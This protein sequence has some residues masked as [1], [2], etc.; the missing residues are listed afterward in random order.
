MSSAS[1]DT[2]TRQLL[3]AAVAA[4]R[5]SANE[6]ARPPQ[7]SGARRHKI[8]VLI[9]ALLVL[10]QPPPPPPLAAVGLNPAAWKWRVCFRM[11]IGAVASLARTHTH[12]HRLVWRVKFCAPRK[13]IGRRRPFGCCRPTSCLASGAFR[14]QRPALVA[15]A[16]GQLSDTHTSSGDGGGAAAAAWATRTARAIYGAS[17]CAVI[18]S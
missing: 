11:Q 4:D 14:P 18:K 3:G 1:Q 7:A 12:T 9:D 10:P 8:G 15:A 13:S 16:A 6:V 5:A 2:P 17:L